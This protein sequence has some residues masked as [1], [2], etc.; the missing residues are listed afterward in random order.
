M[1]LCLMKEFLAGKITNPL[2]LHPFD[3]AVR[4]YDSQLARLTQV[5][6]S[7]ARFAD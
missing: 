5:V 6:Q 2:L 4:L 7:I 1:I 3:D